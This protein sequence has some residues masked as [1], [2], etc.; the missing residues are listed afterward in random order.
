MRRFVTLL[1][2]GSVVL[3][4][5]PAPAT[6]GT[7]MASAC[8]AGVVPVS[9]Y[10][11]RAGAHAASVDCLRWWRLQLGSTEDFRYGTSR[12]VTRLEHARLLANLLDATGLEDAGSPLDQGFRDVRGTE[13][14]PDVNRLASLGVVRGRNAS[15]F[16]PDG[17][18]RRDQMAALFVR[19]HE[20]A[21]GRTLPLG[22]R[23]ADIVGSVHED[24][25]RR[26]VGGGITAGRTATTY[27][28]AGLVTHGQMASFL[29]RY[30]GLLVD[31]GLAEPPYLPEPLVVSGTAGETVTV[32]LPRGAR[33]LIS[34]T[35]TNPAAAEST[36][37]PTAFDANRHVGREFYCSPPT[38]PVETAVLNFHAT[39]PWLDPPQIVALRADDFAWTA[40]IRDVHNA[41]VVGPEGASRRARLEVL[42]VLAIAGR[43]VTF[44]SEAGALY[45]VAAFDGYGSL[46]GI[47]TWP[48]SDGAANCRFQLPEAAH[49]IEVGSPGDW[50]L[51]V[52]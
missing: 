15:E 16:D 51:V 37:V 9:D 32:D 5:L 21:Y 1:A 47:G 25:I 39:Y 3:G 20:Q 18:I 28:P 29:M 6:A 10:V 44:V 40:T 12:E 31:L 11:D 46:T 30:V 7:E 26:L 49:W 45:A 19:L 27:D 50:R 4:I 17:P 14:A 2:A 34:C 33:L 42:D 8:P 23:F 41:R 52:E 38:E 43:Y 35:S 22:P 36:L 48:C 13:H 24:S